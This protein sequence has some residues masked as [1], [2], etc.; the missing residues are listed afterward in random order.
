MIVKINDGKGSEITVSLFKKANAL[1]QTKAVVTSFMPCLLGILFATYYY[2]SFH[3]ANSLMITISVV[4]FHL[5][6]NAHNQY[7]DYEHFRGKNSNN[8]ILKNFSITPAQARTTIVG[9]TL[10]SMVIGLILVDRTGLP[11]LWVGMVSFAVGYF[12]SG[13]PYPI[14]KTPFG[15]LFSGLTMG[16]NITFLATYVNMYQ[17]IDV[18][19]LWYKTL[20]VAIPAVFTISDIM[21]ANNI[22]DRHEDP[23][24][25]RKT[26]VYY[27]GKRG[28]ILLWQ[29]SFVLA[30]VGIIAAVVLAYLPKS[31]LL[32][33]LTVPIVWRNTRRFSKRPQKGTTF[34]YAII[35]A[36]LI[37]AATV[38]GGGLA[39]IL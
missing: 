28:G 17:L 32:A 22:A 18:S 34:L 26:I 9:L 1:V 10:F 23:A 25:G 38:I 14:S 15:E 31:T 2:R 30:Y 35:N 24:L 8:N 4:A 7:K 39:L 21:L 20:I 6:V 11:V 19:G 29:V 33:L 3:L 27:W 16:Y 36:Q 13:G 12:Y 37:L 5:A